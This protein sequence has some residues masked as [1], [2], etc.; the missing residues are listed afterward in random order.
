MNHC[1]S[2]EKDCPKDNQDLLRYPCSVRANW[3]GA[4]TVQRRAQRA[5]KLNRTEDR[6]T[7]NSKH[8][9]TV[10]ETLPNSQSS[11]KGA[12]LMPILR[13]RQC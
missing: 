9:T 12:G 11:L 1:P 13:P 3:P 4:T 5:R 7:V 10:Q 8:Q 2:V 6:G